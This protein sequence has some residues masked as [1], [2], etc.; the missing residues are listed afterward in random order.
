MVGGLR[1]QDLY[2]QDHSLSKNSEDTHMIHSHGDGEW[3]VYSF[4]GIFSNFFDRTVD[5]INKYNPD[6]VY[7]DDTTCLLALSDQGLRTVA[8]FYNKSLK[9]N[10]GENKAVVFAKILTDEQKECLV[11]MWKRVFQ[12]RCRINPGRHVLVSGIGIMIRMLMTMVGINQLRL[13]CTC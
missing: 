1:P 5:M 4:R 8:H 11:W 2:A 7:Y 13:S 10:N 9:E 3:S 6:L 12:I